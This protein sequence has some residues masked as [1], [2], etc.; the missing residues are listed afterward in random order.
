MRT[1]TAK[2]PLTEAQKTAVVKR[3]IALDHTPTNEEVEMI[4]E[5]VRAGVAPI[6]NN[7]LQQEGADIP[8]AAED[9]ESL[10]TVVGLMGIGIFILII[11]MNFGSAPGTIMQM[12]EVFGSVFITCLIVG[13]CLAVLAAVLKKK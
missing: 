7:I 1:T 13:T 9:K 11:L 5:Q 8:P 4:E 10:I 12:G 6:A 2:Q 3:I